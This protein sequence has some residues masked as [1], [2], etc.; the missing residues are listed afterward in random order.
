MGPMDEWPLE[1]LWRDAPIEWISDG[2]S[3]IQRYIV[4]RERLR[5]HEA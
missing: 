5:P 1:M 4:G 3:E 2:S